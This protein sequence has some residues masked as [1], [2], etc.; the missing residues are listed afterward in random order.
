MPVIAMSRTEIDRMIVSQDSAA[1]RIRGTEAATLLGLGQRQV[2][3]QA[4]AFAQR[5]RKLVSQ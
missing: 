2:F 1:S 3:R 4:K 5:G